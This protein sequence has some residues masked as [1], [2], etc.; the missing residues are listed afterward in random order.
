MTYLRNNT[1]YLEWDEWRVYLAVGHL[2]SAG[3]T[4]N[5][6]QLAAWTDMSRTKVRAIAERLARRGYLRDSAPLKA[7]PHWRTTNKIAR[8]SPSP[9]PSPSDSTI[10]HDATP[11]AI[12]HDDTP[13]DSTIGQRPPCGLPRQY[14][15]HGPG[16]WCDE[17]CAPEPWCFY[18]HAGAGEPHA[19]WCVAR[20]GAVSV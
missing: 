20:A 15:D 6:S 8:P 2:A 19:D 13:S 16:V 3:R 1:E 17:S 18:C 12:G 9:S 11:C 10:G 7:A 5:N 4:V 14:H